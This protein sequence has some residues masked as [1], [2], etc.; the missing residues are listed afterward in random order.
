MPAIRKRFAGMARSYMH[1][2]CFL[3]YAVCRLG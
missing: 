3:L 2:V 1:V